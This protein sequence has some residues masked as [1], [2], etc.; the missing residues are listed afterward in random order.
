MVSFFPLH[1]GGDGAAERIGIGEAYLRTIEASQKF[2]FSQIAETFSRELLM[3]AVE[4]ASEGI[5]NFGIG[6]SRKASQLSDFDAWCSIVV[7][8][9]YYNQYRNGD[10]ISVDKDDIVVY[11]WLG[12]KAIG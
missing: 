11:Q 6:R 4:A 2:D 8:G 3:T 10:R 9:G 1:Q 12:L 7:S 5:F